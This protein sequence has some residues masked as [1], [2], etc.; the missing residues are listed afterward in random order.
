M[1]FLHEKGFAP[2]IL[3]IVSLGGHRGAAGFPV[4]P[5]PGPVSALRFARSPAARVAAAGQLKRSVSR[6]STCHGQHPPLIRTL[7]PPRRRARGARPARAHRAGVLCRRPA[8]ALRRLLGVLPH[9]S[10]PT[11][12]SRPPTRSAC[13]NARRSSPTAGRRT[14]SCCMTTPSWFKKDK[15][16]VRVP[17]DDRDGDDGGGIVEGQAA[18]HGCSGDRS[19]A[20]CRADFARQ[21]RGFA[22]RRPGKSTGFAACDAGAEP[23]PACGEPGSCHS[24]ACYS[25]TCA[26]YSNTRAG[27]SRSCRARA[28]AGT[29]YAGP[30]SRSRDADSCPGDASP[31]TCDADP[32]TCRCH[33]DARSCRTG[34]N[35]RYT[36]TCRDRFADACGCDCGGQRRS[37]HRARRTC[38]AYSDPN[39]CRADA[40]LL[41]GSRPRDFGQHAAASSSFARRFRVGF[42]RHRSRPAWSHARRNPAVAR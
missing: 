8:D 23:D 28:D 20:E 11:E 3:D 36:D 26:C 38:S 30:N 9:Q 32:C 15:G 16:L 41:S 35:T 22:D 42:T 31:C 37:R 7:R 19:V 24:R 33:A 14:T 13:S 5:G 39:A 12:T 25:D 17:I 18:R 1:P 40:R 34:G 21:G 10:R 6:F 27:H 2:H 4:H 29:A